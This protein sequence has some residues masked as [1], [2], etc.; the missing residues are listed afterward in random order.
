MKTNL[1]IALSLANRGYLA[2]SDIELAVD[3][4][5]ESIPIKAVDALWKATQD[6]AYQDH[7]LTQAIE[8]HDVDVE[9]GA[10]VD[11]A[12]Q[13]NIEGAALD[14]QDEDLA[15]MMAAR[16]EIIA[17][18]QK[19]TS[20]LADEELIEAAQQSEVQAVIAESWWR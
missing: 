10:W 7:Q 6:D 15:K 9:M 18:A 17:A 3:V 2:V 19:A 5:E 11:A 1:D 12:H 20:A 4:L 14:H 8:T 16:A 13:Q